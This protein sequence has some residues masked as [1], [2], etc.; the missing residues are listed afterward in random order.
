MFSDLP[1]QLPAEPRASWWQAIFEAS[2]DALLVC[3]PDGEI[4]EANPRAQKIFESAEWDLQRPLFD[5]LTGPTIQ[6]LK[7]ILARGARF[8]EQLA[9]VSFLPYGPLRMV[10]DLV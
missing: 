4:Y 10:V 2:E 7:A 8:P 3:A 9:S 6:R 1:T 5:A